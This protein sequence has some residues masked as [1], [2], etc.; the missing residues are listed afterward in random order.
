MRYHPLLFLILSPVIVAYYMLWVVFKSVYWFAV[1]LVATIKWLGSA[2]TDWDA[3]R[4][5]KDKRRG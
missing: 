1:L 4:Y 3:Y 2:M 5:L